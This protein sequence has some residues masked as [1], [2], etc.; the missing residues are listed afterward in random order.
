MLGK[1]VGEMSHLGKRELFGSALGTVKSPK[2]PIPGIMPFAAVLAASGNL[3][4]GN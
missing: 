4:A 1:K 2:S 3:S